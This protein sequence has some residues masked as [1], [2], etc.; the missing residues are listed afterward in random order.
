MELIRGLHNLRPRHAGSAV[1]VGN[2]DG[3]HLGHAALIGQLAE[4][5]AEMALPSTLITFEP[6]PREF[7]APDNS[8][9]RLTRLR[10]KLQA[11]SNTRLERVLLLRFDQ[12]LAGMAPGDFVERILVR[13]LGARLVMVGEDFRFGHR[14]EGTLDMLRALGEQLGFEVRCFDNF[15]IDGARSSSSWVRDALAA[16]NLELAAKLL[17]RPYSISGRVAQGQRLGRTI[18]FATANVPLGR[19]APAL[20]GVFAVRVHGLSPTALPAMA[21]IGTRPTVQGTGLLLEVHVFDFDCDVY[22]CQVQ[23]EFVAKLRDE[24]EFDGLD[25]LKAQLHRDALAARAAL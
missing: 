4:A 18:G 3:V 8:P 7:F 16:G 25:A 11:L 14:A 15:K 6:Q 5:A 20:S 19:V 13:G 2:F 22:G 21:N 12:A 1:T 23:V 24:R 17:G 9:P 10:E